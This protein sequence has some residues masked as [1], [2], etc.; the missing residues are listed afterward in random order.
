MLRS[1]LRA[2][3]LQAVGPDLPR[4]LLPDAT[5]KR[6]GHVLATL[7]PLLIGASGTILEQLGAAL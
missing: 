6:I 2:E 4:V 5:R 3:H 1:Q 7:A